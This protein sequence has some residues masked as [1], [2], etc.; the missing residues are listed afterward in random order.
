MG[1]GGEQDAPRGWRH[2]RLLYNAYR[3][4]A[5]GVKLVTPMTEKKRKEK[6]RKER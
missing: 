5:S 1:G 4:K 2:R 3:M 6:K